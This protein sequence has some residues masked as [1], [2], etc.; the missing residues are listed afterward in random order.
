MK[1]KKFHKVCFWAS[2]NKIYSN[3]FISLAPIE[4]SDSDEN[5]KKKKNKSKKNLTSEQVP[6]VPIKQEVTPPPVIEPQ[7]VS[8]IAQQEPTPSRMF[9]FST[10]II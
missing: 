3:Y 2:K 4:W 7:P 8:T 5:D 1:L 6:T 10:N 9:Y